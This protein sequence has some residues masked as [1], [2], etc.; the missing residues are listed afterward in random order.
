MF[1]EVDPLV[2]FVVPAPTW[3]TACA[4]DSGT[5]DTRPWP[6][7]STIFANQLAPDAQDAA[8]KTQIFPAGPEVA[9]IAGLPHTRTRRL[10]AGLPQPLKGPGV[11]GYVGL[12][13]IVRLRTFRSN[14]VFKDET[15]APRISI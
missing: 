1:Q 12:N 5:V 11:G 4:F 9:D 13:L 15:R 14:S 8:G 7:L 3:P 2:H 10:R 6:P